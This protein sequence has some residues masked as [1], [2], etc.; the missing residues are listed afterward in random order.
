[1]RDGEELEGKVEWVDEDMGIRESRR[2]D[3]SS[4]EDAFEVDWDGVPRPLFQAGERIIIEKRMTLMPGRPWLN[5]VTYMVEEVNQEE[6]LLKLWNEDL[7][8]WD[9]SHYISGIKKHG[10]LY[11]LLKKKSTV[12]L[13]QP[14]QTTEKKRGR[15]FKP[16][17]VGKVPLR[18]GGKKCGRG[19]PKRGV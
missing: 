18:E 12:P 16:E 15:P 14:S 17:N 6:G 11:K 4:Y 10:F 3:L 5:T 2:P 7:Q 13:A 9:R 19:R 8:Q 1:M